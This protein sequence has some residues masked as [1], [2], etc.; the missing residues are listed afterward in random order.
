VEVLLTP[1]LGKPP[2][3]HGALFA[4]G[5]EARVQAF[6]ARHA[7]SMAI[8]LPGVLDK[9]VKRAFAFA[10]FTPIANVSGQPSMSVPLHDSAEGLPIGV[11]FTA[12]F[13]DEA[14]LFR[15]A[16]QLEA[17][18]PWRERRPPVHAGG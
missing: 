15:L 12:R 8:K 1:T 4:K 10:P 2:V 6:V 5:L 13:G 17:A 16:G 3:P 11:C 7:L 9:A 18:R 14:T